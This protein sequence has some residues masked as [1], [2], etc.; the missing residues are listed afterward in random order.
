MAKV[1]ERSSWSA[2][3]ETDFHAWAEKQAELLRARRFDE[4]DLAHLIEEVAD[5]ATYQR[6]SVVSRARRILQHFLKLEYSPAS[7]PRR[8]WKET[9]VTQRTDL[10]E[11]LTAS[12]RQE[13]AG[14]LADTYG[15]ARRDA[16]RDLK[17]DQVSERDLPVACPYTLEQ[18]LDPDWL[19]AN[20]H[21]IKDPQR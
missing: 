11:R 18:V 9:I 8:G 5:L 2:L 17:P 7:E 4:L 21:G 1:V 12:L 3:Y 14:A 20:V 15:R 6:H 13:L 10:E 19:P 16:V